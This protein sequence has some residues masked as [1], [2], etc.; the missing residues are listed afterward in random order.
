MSFPE[1]ANQTST[2]L[3]HD[4][5]ARSGKERPMGAAMPRLR[6]AGTIRALPARCRPLD[7]GMRESA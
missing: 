5:V 4:S 2:F 3:T 1:E 7:A 6:V